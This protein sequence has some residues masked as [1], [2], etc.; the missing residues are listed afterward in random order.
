M[1]RPSA[2]DSTIRPTTK[3]PWSAEVAEHL[4]VTHHVEVIKPRALELFEHLMHFMDDPIGDFS[5]FPTYLVSQAGASAR[6]RW[7][8]PETAA[9]SCSAATRLIWPR[10]SARTWAR[11]PRFLRAGVIE[12]AVAA[13]PPTLAKKGLREQGQAFR[14]GRATRCAARSREMARVR[15]AHDAAQ[16]VHCLRTGAN[17][18]PASATTF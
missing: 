18:T 14:R 4:G 9:T 13:L 2:S 15:R 11:I 10:R 16:A 3:L 8:C 7:P 6:Q 17:A 1:L 5:I 12:P